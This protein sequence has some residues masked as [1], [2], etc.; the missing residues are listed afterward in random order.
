LPQLINRIPQLGNTDAGNS[1]VLRILRR[2]SIH[3]G[4]NTSFRRPKNL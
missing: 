4:V 2:H 1:A 3:G